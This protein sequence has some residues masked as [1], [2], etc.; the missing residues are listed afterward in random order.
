M[1]KIIQ[2]I[3]EINDASFRWYLVISLVLISVDSLG[4]GLLTEIGIAQSNLYYF[5]VVS[6][7]LE[8]IYYRSPLS[9]QISSQANLLFGKKTG[10][11][12]VYISGLF[13]ILFVIFWYQPTLEIRRVIVSDGLPTFGASF[14][15]GITFLFLL[16]SVSQ[17]EQSVKNETIDQKVIDIKEIYRNKKELIKSHRL[18]QQYPLRYYVHQTEYESIVRFI[19]EEETVLDNGC[20]DGALAILLAKKRAIVTACDISEPNIEVAEYLA[21]EEGVGNQI[22]FLTA[23]AENLPFPDNS[24]DWVVSSH[25]LEHLPN[26]EKGLAEVYRVTKKR[27]V[28]ALP[29]CL[30]PCAMVILGGDN[31]WSIS[32]WTPFAWFIGLGKIILNL[33]GEGV[34]EGYGGHQELPHIWRYPWVM[35]KGLKRV[36]FKIVHFEAS[37]LVLPYFNF[38]LPF[39][40]YLEKFK[41]KPIIRNFGYGSIAL[42]EK[43]II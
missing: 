9:T 6:F 35:K 33:G 22:K 17:Q 2:L 34:D 29:T 14:L 16:I 36:G 20:G 31:F 5:L 4:R 13:L 10:Q 1:N 21:R 38:L 23:D 39:S 18:S 7:L 25:V 41:A 3:L 12:L 40:K 42:V 43:N 30:N 24:F 11:L 32:R 8:I 19:K 37:S 27:A 15:L 28:I 26:F